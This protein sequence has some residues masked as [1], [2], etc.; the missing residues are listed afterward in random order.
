MARTMSKQEQA[1]EIMAD[2]GLVTDDMV[3]ADDENTAPYILVGSASIPVSKKAGA[4]WKDKIDTALNGYD[5][6]RQMWEKAFQE[7]QRTN[8][9]GIKLDGDS[10]EA[11]LYFFQNNTD[12]NLT[13]ENVKS[14][15]RNTY[16]RNPTI[17]LS[18]IDGQDKKAVKALTEAVNSLLGRVQ[19]PGINAKAR[20]RRWIMHAH[21]TN[22]GCLKLDFQAMK[23]SRADAQFQLGE[24]QR[25]LSEAKDQDSIE[26]L[27]AELEQIDEELPSTREA[28][29]NLSNVTAGM[30]I[31][32]PDCT[33]LDLTTAKWCDEIVMLSEAYIKN[34]FLEKN[35]DGAWVRKVDG[36]QPGA[37]FGG[38]PSNRNEIVENVI[39]EILGTMPDSI[40]EARNKGKVKCH[41]IWDKLTKQ[42]SLW[43]D[44]A[45]DY[46][47][48]VYKD[49]LQLTRFYPYHFLSF[50]EP[51]DS[52]VQE[53]ESAQ[54]FGHVQ[55]INKINARVSFLRMLAYGSLIYNSKKIKNSEV[56]A[57][58]AHMKNPNAFEAFGIE[59]DPALK[60]KEM[61][62][63]FVP[64]ESDIQGIY[65]KGDLYR[66]ADRITS[67]SSV[68]RGE[69]F[70]TNTTNKAVEAYGAVQ[71]S[72]TNE[73]TD[74]VEDGLQD[75]I[76]SMLELIVSKYTKEQI[77]ALIG[78]ELAKDF[79]PMTVVEFNQKFSLT[80][81]SG[82]T[83]KPT[84][85]NKKREAM[86]MAQAI[87]Q[88]GQATPMTTLKI[89]FRLF[90]T[91]FSSFLFTPEDESML[92]KEAEANMTKGQSVPGQPPEAGAGST[93][94]PAA[95][96][97]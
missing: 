81:A 48:W 46:P 10:G 96:P 38:Q 53:G 88:V 91:A 18:T 41:L 43:I 64:P 55:E 51:L 39:N 34:R 44:G 22:M 28:G 26:A 97:K 67:T 62:D 63:V 32:D 89:I 52:I 80:I 70:K 20:I 16:T 12:E 3:T 56:T 86:E 71:A 78:A 19:S 9:Y 25:K 4:R 33:T 27:Y 1:S 8:N 5:A 14:L 69:Q 82:S 58:V 40:A 36:K 30:I 85:D 72:V 50:T 74:A 21:L 95:T 42:I 37:G 77:V 75:L 87:G 23:G 59:W 47:L 65:D 45:W 11:P 35:A 90:K 79:T 76:W 73:L 94:P 61:F 83:E 7:Y 92:N 68:Q 31:V 60:L 57:L 54:Y 93:P 13:R 29:L 84:S 2:T 17:E 24:I 15:L 6:T 66:V 49:D